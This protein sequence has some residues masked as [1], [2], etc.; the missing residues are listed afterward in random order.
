MLALLVSACSSNTPCNPTSS[1]FDVVVPGGLDS[2]A[3][4]DAT[5]ACG[6]AFGGCSP[7]SESCATSG[8][9]CQYTA[10]VNANTFG[11]D[12]VCHVRAVSKT[13]LV[14]AQ[15]FPFMRSSES[16]FTGHTGAVT[17]DFSGAGIVDAGTD[18][19]SDVG[20]GPGPATD[21][22]SDGDSGS[23]AAD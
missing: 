3:S 12:P 9:P 7:V 16:C 10:Q 15:D 5:G 22:G 17:V 20:Q 19:G 6:I 14:F 1:V 23:D 8:C 13:G 18:A 2:I 21:A 11:A 4:V